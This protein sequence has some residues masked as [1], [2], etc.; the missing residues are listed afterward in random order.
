M[1]GVCDGNGPYGK[2]SANF[3]KY[4]LN[5]AIEN[6]FPQEGTEDS[7][8][9]IKALKNSYAAVHYSMKQNVPDPSYSGST[10]CCVL[11]LG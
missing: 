8:G 2:E 6:N 11:T 3:C 7:Q 9:I 10:G 4:G 1:F 5:K